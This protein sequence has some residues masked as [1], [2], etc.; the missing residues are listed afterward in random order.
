MILVEQ[1]NNPNLKFQIIIK[2]NKYNYKIKGKKIR[3]YSSLLQF[4]D[5]HSK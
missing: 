4:F 2:I 5:I 1:M 3:L